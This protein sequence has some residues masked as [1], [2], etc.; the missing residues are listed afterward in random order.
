MLGC[1]K[2]H[3][4][5]RV[6]PATPATPNNPQENTKETKD[7][8]E[9]KFKPTQSFRATTELFKGRQGWDTSVTEQVQCHPGPAWRLLTI[10][11]G[12][13]R[14]QVLTLKR[15]GIFSAVSTRRDARHGKKLSTGTRNQPSS[16]DIAEKR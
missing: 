8:L 11:H 16:A 15:C 3:S 2:G 7:T 5:Q 6:H 14:V 12:L 10:R 4:H 9:N 13:G 1:D